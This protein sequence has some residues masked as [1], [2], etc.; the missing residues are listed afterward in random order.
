MIDFPWIPDVLPGFPP[1]HTPK[2]CPRHP[3][4]LA[5]RVHS[6]SQESDD[7]MLR[8]CV[9]EHEGASGALLPEPRCLTP[10][11]G[12]AMVLFCMCLRVHS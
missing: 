9:W 8:L 2:H 7:Q 1:L 11:R 4:H 10:L 3:C 6:L 5:L 12:L